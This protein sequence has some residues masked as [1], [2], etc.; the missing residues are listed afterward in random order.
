M[1]LLSGII[2]LLIHTKLWR[3][4]YSFCYT[5]TGCRR[6]GWVLDSEGYCS[7]ATGGQDGST[8]TS[9]HHWVRVKWCQWI[10][11]YIFWCLVEVPQ[12]LI[13][14]ME[15]LYRIL[16]Y[17]L[18]FVVI[19]DLTILGIRWLFFWQALTLVVCPRR[20]TERVFGP[21]QWQELR[22]GLSGW[23]VSSNFFGCHAGP[24]TLVY[25]FFGSLEVFVWINWYNQSRSL[26]VFIVIP[27]LGVLLL[28]L[29]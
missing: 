29:W 19:F 22:R 18:S 20:C 9:C 4:W 26:A 3:G 21:A 5:F 23:K 15:L 7:K 11:S 10:I 24:A 25:V 14:T 1:T 6:R 12:L 17:Y 16:V 2:S 13:H 27:R 8:E 28:D